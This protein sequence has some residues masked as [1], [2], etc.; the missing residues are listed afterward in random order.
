M[1]A[2]DRLWQMDI[3]RRAAEGKLSQVLGSSALDYDKL[4]RTIGIDKFSYRWYNNISPKSREILQAYSKGVNKFIELHAEK[5]PA[6]FDILNYK[7][8]QWKPEHS[9]MVGRLMAWDLNT[10]WYTDYIFKEIVDKI[11]LEKASE[12]FP[13]SSISIYKK[14]KPEI[15]TT[16]IIKPSPIERKI[17]NDTV[18]VVPPRKKKI[19][20][21]EPE[22]FKEE[23]PEEPPE[24]KDTGK[25]GHSFFEMYNS[26]R[27]FFNM[28]IS[29]SGSNSWVVSGK[30]TENGKPL[31][32]ND[33][34]L[35]FQAPSKWYEV[36]LKS[37]N[38]DVTGMSVPGIPAVIIGHNRTICWGLTNL[39]NDDNDFLLLGRDSL[40][41]S[42]YYYEN[43]PHYLDSTVEKIEVKNSEDVY[44]TVY[45]SKAGPIISNIKGQEDKNSY[46]TF[47]WTGYEYSDELEC[48]YEISTAGNW[49]DFTNGLRHF[50]V[51]AQNFTYADTM[52][53]IG[54]HAAGKI[55]VRKSTNGDY[56]N[57]TGNNEWTGF[58]EFDKLPNEF[59]PDEGYIVTAN[60]NPFEWLKT[61]PSKRYFISWGWEPSSRFNKIKEVLQNKNLLDADEFKLVQV[62]YQSLY[63]QEM[64]KYIIEAFKDYKAEGDIL[65]AINKLKN[66][67]G[68][69]KA[70]S[71][72]GAIYSAFL[73][74]LI[75]N[76]FLDELGEKTFF[77]FLTVGNLPLRATMKLLRDNE[78]SDSTWFDNINTSQI[79]KKDEIIRKSFYE[80]MSFLKL[81]FSNRD[82]NSWKWGD[83]HHAKFMH[84]MGTIGALD[85]TFNVGPFEIGGDQTTVNN[86]EYSFIKAIRDGTFEND[87]GPS[88]RMIT[89]LSDITHSLSINSTGQSGQPLHPDYQNQSRLW[90][91]GDYKENVMNEKEMIDRD[92]NLLQLTP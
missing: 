37:I 14:P 28:S 13:D 65:E 23:I 3:T 84:V 7:P 48:F 71:P 66:W 72:E 29:G 9:L 51:P 6:E 19:K 39:M 92:Y 74:H 75:K 41:N 60:T 24:K 5:L 32:A 34:H 26:Y 62:N 61:E 58:V 46:L 4:F 87:L 31:L 90:L 50:G 20:E 53:N 64:S 57:F 67:S 54:Y 10:S 68:E 1:H 77:D 12:I 69:M 43:Q 81:K 17:E 80:G 86:S 33:P 18:S 2:R 59:N 89:D 25:G 82:I 78:V 11:G 55:P 76:I 56:V 70:D 45:N 85:K 88:M 21:E 35:N 79:E 22:E 42:V 47:R 40:E 38:L 49:D 36:Q 44:L 83:I 91:Y 16:H 73:V 8:E 63:A 52:G 27:N 30:K 15:D